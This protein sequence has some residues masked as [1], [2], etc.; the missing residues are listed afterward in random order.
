MNA[1]RPRW[2]V[3]DPA[4]GLLTGAYFDCEREDAQ[5]M[6][7]PGMAIVQGHIDHRRHRIDPDTAEPVPYRPPAPADTE[8]VA[9]Q[10]DGERA[11]YVQH[12]TPAGARKRLLR[13]ADARRDADMAAPGVVE[14]EGHE[15]QSDER[16]RAALLEAIGIN[17]PRAWT[18]LDNEDVPMSVAKM[19]GLLEAMFGLRSAI[20]DQSRRVKDAIRASDDPR[21]LDVSAMWSEP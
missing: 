15:Y 11:E 16:S 8:D 2:N 6:T 7:P 14:F 4:T 5:R 20:R 17:K 18:T 12:E 3:Y 1:D 10:W 9:W 21:A 19:R 13:E